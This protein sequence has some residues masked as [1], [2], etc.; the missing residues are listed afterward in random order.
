M[1]Q[2]KKF[3]ITQ[4][5]RT[6]NVLIASGLQLISNIGTTYTFL[7]QLPDKFNFDGVDQ[8]KIIYT[9]ILSL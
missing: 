9:N 1:L 2:N 4:D 5:K 3:I 6:A 7:N 8:K